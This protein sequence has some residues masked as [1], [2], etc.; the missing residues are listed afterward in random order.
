MLRIMDMTEATS[1]DEFTFAVWDTVRDEFL[2]DKYG[3]QAWTLEEF[4]EGYEG[5][6]PDAKERVKSM[7]AS[8]IENH[9]FNTDIEE[10]FTDISYS[11]PRKA[12]P[13]GL[14]GL[15]P[16]AAE[17]DLCDEHSRLPM[18]VIMDMMDTPISQT[19]SVIAECFKCTLT[20]REK[21][22]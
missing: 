11:D 10:K 14:P 20:I 5:N 8:R 2:R 6:V 13:P 15:K 7:V 1:S 12:P 19:P 17:W 16:I 3:D 22:Q 9:K 4:L 21:E 18:E